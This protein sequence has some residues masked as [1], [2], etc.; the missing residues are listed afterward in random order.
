MAHFDFNRTGIRPEDRARIL[1]EVGAMKDVTWQTVRTTGYTDSVGS[2]GANQRLA[3]R[4]AGAV[5]HYL[6]V[7]GLDPAM[8]DVIARGEADPVADNASPTGRAQNRRT[9]VEFQGIRTVTR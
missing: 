6:V 7:K 5:K 3:A 2:A 4:R 9:E 1:A 8:I